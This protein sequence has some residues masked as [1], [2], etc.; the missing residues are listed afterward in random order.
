MPKRV[1]FR[2]E[3]L[4]LPI[5]SNSMDLSG[6]IFG[7][8]MSTTNDAGV[9]LFN[10]FRYMGCIGSSLSLGGLKVAPRMDHLP[11]SVK[12]LNSLKYV[13]E[14]GRVILLQYHQ[15]YSHFTRIFLLLNTGVS[16]GSIRGTI[17]LGGDSLDSHLLW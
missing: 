17:K 15:T 2:S 7:S 16:T 11:F 9:C 12:T 10:G 3:R 6:V 1:D 4:N 13:S 5:S 8:A 14:S